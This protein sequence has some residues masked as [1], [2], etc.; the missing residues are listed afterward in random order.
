VALNLEEEEETQEVMLILAEV[1]RRTIGHTMTGSIL[2]TITILR[3]HELTSPVLMTPLLPPIFMTDL[4][5][6]TASTPVQG[7]YEQC[8]QKDLDM[9]SRY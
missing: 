4:L 3:I 2:I 8:V 1:S 6:I 9:D 7:M 5:V